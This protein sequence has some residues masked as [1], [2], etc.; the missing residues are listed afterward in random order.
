[1]FDRYKERFI[2]LAE[3]KRYLFDY[4]DLDDDHRCMLKSV[5]LIAL[6][7]LVVLFV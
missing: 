3:K 5:L 6:L 7:V 2:S 4:G 1:M